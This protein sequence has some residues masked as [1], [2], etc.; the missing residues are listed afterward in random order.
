MANVHLPARSG[1]GDQLLAT[2]LNTAG[3]PEHM[4]HMLAAG[5][6]GM[7]P[8]TGTLTTSTS[9]VTHTGTTSAGNAQMLIYG[10]YAGVNVSFEG[11]V[12]GGGV[13]TTNWIP[14]AAVRARDNMPETSSGALP[15]NTVAGWQMDVSG[16][17]QV[18][19]RATAWT[20]GTA[21]IIIQPIV[22]WGEPVV[23]SV[24]SPPTTR[25]ERTLITG[26]TTTPAAV[27]G[28]VAETATSLVSIT[29]AVNTT[30]ATTFTPASG[31][32]FQ[33][34]NINLMVISGAATIASSRVLLRSNPAGT[35]T[36]TSPVLAMLG[37]T[38]N[39]AVSGAAGNADM[40]SDIIIPPGWSCMLTHSEN[41]T[42]TTFWAVITGYE[43]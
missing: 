23:A 12:G 30:A 40:A 26:A 43:F 17:D 37:A 4:Q 24:I 6:V 31:K 19:V 22:A 10:T 35:A 2:T 21:N 25:A 38:S 1:V 27:T 14:I 16:F 29:N 20:S 18:R 42:T 5:T 32:S 9:T 15:S 3:T 28:V 39:A 13:N 41:A 7:T 36:T 33:I 34:K 11:L 8:Q